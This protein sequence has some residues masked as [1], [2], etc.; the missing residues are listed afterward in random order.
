MSSNR[1]TRVA[2]PRLTP[3]GLLPLGAYFSV[4]EEDLHPDDI[5]TSTAAFQAAAAAAAS[6]ASQSRFPAAE[7]LS[8]EEDDDEDDEE[9][10]DDEDEDDDGAPGPSGTATSVGDEEAR[11]FDPAAIEGILSGQDESTPIFNQLFGAIDYDEDERGGVAD[12]DMEELQAQMAYEEG[13]SRKRRRRKPARRFKGAK[14]LT[15]EQSRLLGEANMAYTQGQYTEAIRYL[16]Q[17]IRGAPYAH[18][19]WFTLAMIHEELEDADK[20][21]QFYLIAAHLTPKDVELWK[22]LGDMSTWV[23]DRQVLFEVSVSTST[24]NLL[25]DELVNSNR[26]STVSTKL[27]DWTKT[28]STPFLAGVESTRHLA[29]SAR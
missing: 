3:S 5:L 7:V 1:R 19:A 13:T 9:D 17:L 2:C 20:A 27:F 26:P 29:L 4:E 14:A 16:H 10:Y 22:R 21:L 23:F 12:E 8:G 18:Q 6:H 25:T 15:D 24:S 11:P 28:T